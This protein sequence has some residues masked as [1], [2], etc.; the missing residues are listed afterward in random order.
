MVS[1]GHNTRAM[2]SVRDLRKCDSDL[3]F[4]KMNSIKQYITKNYDPNRSHS[5]TAVVADEDLSFG[6]SLMYETMTEQ[7]PTKIWIFKDME[8]AQKWLKENL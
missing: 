7:I 1:P 5:V 3:D 6:L 2:S 4:E 8:N